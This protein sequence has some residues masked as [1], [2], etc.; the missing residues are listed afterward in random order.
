[1]AGN[2]LTLGIDL[3]KNQIVL[4]L[5][6]KAWRG[7]RLIDYQVRA[8]EEGFSVEDQLPFI[9]NF[10]AAYPQAKDKVFLALP[11]E[12]TVI[13]F[14]RL[15][16]AAQENLRQVLTYEAPKYVP[17]E[18]E[19]I[20]FDYQVLHRDRL[21]LDL[22][23]L[24]SKK[25]DIAYYLAL[26]EKIGLTPQNIQIS[27]LGAINL[28]LYQSGANYKKNTVL[29]D[30]QGSIV[31]I[32]LL[33]EG[34][35]QENF[36][37]PLAPEEKGE[38]IIQI[39]QMS[40]IPE[41]ELEQ[42]EFYLYG[43]GGESKSGSSWPEH[44]S[45]KHIAPPP[46]NKIK[47]RRGESFLSAIYASLGVP[48]PGI[49]KT[50]YK[51]NLLAEEKKKKTRQLGKPFFIS[52]LSLTMLLTLTWIWGSYQKIQDELQFLRAEV[53]KKKPAVA[54]IENL[55]KEREKVLQEIAEFEKLSSLEARKIEILRELTQI[56]PPTVWLWNLKATGGEI[57]IS[58]FAD[59]ASDLIPLL[60]RSHLF[61]KVEF[62]APVTKER[63]RRSGG[64]K[65]RFK[66]RMYLE[67]KRL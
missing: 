17:C 18:A 19:E 7:I 36:F 13:R 43:A 61:E 6:K 50:T 3:G 47:T 5:L 64:E 44:P 1:M 59:S 20:C 12:K 2:N 35:W 15:P 24:F 39:C 37:F 65:E 11:R 10:A 8:G 67:K 62:L 25:G 60:D 58:G 34:K 48:L 42:T 32:N 54:A 22:V 41:T 55:K 33:K 52:L 29:L 4:C 40:G 66:I 31:E 21:G 45:L 9:S 38:K 46:L 16:L 51:L 26:L 28:Y 30:W 53:N 57:E 49:V 63:D 14:L 56:L 23:V 27:S